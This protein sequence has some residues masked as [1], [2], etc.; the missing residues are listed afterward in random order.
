[1]DWQ[2]RLALLVAGIAV[3]VFIFFDYSRRK[4][5]QRRKQ[6]PAEQTQTQTQR[7]EP[8]GFDLDGV[9][10][11]RKKNDAEIKV[12]QKPVSENNGRTDD[13]GINNAKSEEPALEMSTQKAQNAHQT[14]QKSAPVEQLSLD[15]ISPVPEGRES[16]Q[17]SASAQ[18][19]KVISLILRAPSDKSF[20]GKDFMPL[21]LS[22]GLRHG[23][24]QI[25]HRH[26]AGAS[27]KP[28]QVQYSVA[29]AIAPGT[30]DIDHIE[31]F[32]TPAFAFFMQLPGPREP[33][34]AFENMVNTIKLLQQELGGQ[35]LDESKSV[36][37][38]QTH[39]HQ[40]EQLQVYLAQSSRN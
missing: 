40:L 14:R 17:L 30:F 23:D 18:Q 5:R 3:L 29:N 9:G 24:M 36:Y 37:T 33:K 27:G 32:D 6:L 34:K 2:I 31:Q 19:D 21:L 38:E 10:A 22:Q 28:G 8:G 35:I 12:C 4:K 39:Q 15:E 13:A 20:K 26:D 25:F 11:V 1:M 7:I 16:E